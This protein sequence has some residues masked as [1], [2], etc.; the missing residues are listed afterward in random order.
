MALLDRVFKRDLKTSDPKAWNP[1]LWNLY[2][3]QSDAGVTVNEHTALSFGAV[4]ACI[5]LLANTVAQIPLHLYRRQG[6][7]KERANERPIYQLMHSAPN[8]EMTAFRYRQTLQGHLASWGNAYSFIARDRLGRVQSLWPLRPDRM[9]IKPRGADGRM[10]YEYRTS[11]KTHKDLTPDEIWHIPGFGFDG[12][13]GYSIISLARQAIGLGM[14]AEEFGARFYG[15]GTHLGGVAQHPGRLSTEALQNLKK[16]LSEKYG[17]LG[18]SHGIIIFE[19]GMTFEK[20]GIPPEDAQFLQSRQ[21]QV[22]DIARWYGIPPHLIQDETRSTFTNIENQALNFAKYTMTP[23][24]VLW[25]QEASQY[26]LKP[27]ERKTYYFEFLMEHLLRGDSAS[28]ATF[29]RSLWDMGCLSQ[30][31]ILAKE[32]MNPIADGDERFVPM[33]MVPLSQ[34]LKEPEPIQPFG[35]EEEEEEEDQIRLHWRQKLEKRSAA[36]R[37]KIQNSYHRLITE[38]AQNVVNMETRAIGRA[39]TKY[40]SERDVK[41]FDN[42]LQD[43]YENE[44]PEQIRKRFF[45]VYQSFAEQIIAAAANEINAEEPNLY[46]FVQ[47]YMARY[48]QRHQGSSLGQM[49]K[50]IDETKPEELR[51][52][53]DQRTTEW[54][55]KRAEKIAMDE[56]VRFGSAVTKATWAAAGLGYL[57]WSTMGKSC[58]YCEM[59]E[60]RRIPIGGNFL[61]DGEELRPTGSEP[62]LI[63]GGKSHP[64]AHSHCDCILLPG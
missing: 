44:M 36:S 24:L 50:L 38:A 6:D 12:L 57:V 63:N 32:N 39:I 55:E 31:D 28:R 37:Q 34:A 18:K 47:D 41:N 25:E 58:P 52:I 53:V 3:T 46:V 49:R 21:H 5:R 7:G 1:L 30:N 60:G 2:G 64:P 45:P 33:N 40:L 27:E 10:R 9:E 51:D 59:L 48:I 20:I 17:G 15:Q 14:A 62:M 61:E 19:E 11:D 43:F 35:E 22:Q 26:F 8:P 56:K 29:Y 42:W 13:Q 16:D 4:F 54:G 23:W